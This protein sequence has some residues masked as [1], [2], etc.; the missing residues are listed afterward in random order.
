[1]PVQTFEPQRA[2]TAAKIAARIFSRHRHDLLSIARLNSNSPDDAEEA[3][4]DALVYFI[5]SYEAGSEAPPLPWLTVTLKRRCWAIAKRAGQEKE[6]IRRLAREREHQP[7]IESLA[8]PDAMVEIKETSL[9]R[10]RHLLEL[11]RDQRQALMLRGLGYS[12]REISAITGWT[13]TK[14]NRSIREGRAELR[15]WE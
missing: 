3:L 2:A 5:E 14:V 10:R 15:S 11:K 1:M 9:L 8:R 7:S 4:Q 13:Y 12:Y 6:R